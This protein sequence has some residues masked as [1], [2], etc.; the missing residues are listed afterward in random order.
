MLNNYKDFIDRY[1]YCVVRKVFSEDEVIELRRLFKSIE[2]K[3]LKKKHAI[4]IS[5]AE[6]N[7]F[8]PKDD[9]T[10]IL[11]DVVSFKEF[12]KFELLVYNEKILK[13]V[14]KVIGD[15]I[16]YFGE[17]N[18]QSGTGDRGFHKDNRIS[19][20]ENPN[21]EDWVGEF[22]LIRVAI[23]L[24]DTVKY[25]GGVKVVPGSHK[26]P[27]SHFKSGFIIVGSEIGDIVI[28]KFTTTHSGNFK[29]IK[30]FKNLTLHPRIED[31]IPNWLEIDNPNRRRGIFITYGVEGNHLKNHIN[32]LRTRE[33]YLRY[34]K[35]AGTSEFSI[36][37][38]KEKGVKIIRPIEN[39]GE[40]LNSSG[41]ND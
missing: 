5:K 23:Y 8:K 41:F 28:W 22:P 2:K 24:N 19:D 7:G 9:Q 32:Y 14:R 11:G 31:Y 4:T 30:Y 12:S 34:F 37:L 27:T 13:P 35:F 10:L 29:R 15:K 33:D 26:I 20:R 18:M 16:C 1:G 17:S 6:R 3:S 38:A 36:K 39:Y 40:S 21:G 25:S